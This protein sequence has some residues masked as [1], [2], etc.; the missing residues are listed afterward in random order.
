MISEIKIGDKVKCLNCGEEIELT[1]ETFYADADA[2]YIKCNYCGFIKDVQAYHMSH[3]FPW[4]LFPAESRVVVEA[5]MEF[6]KSCGIEVDYDYICTACGATM[7]DPDGYGHLW[8]EREF[9]N[10]DS[11]L[12]KIIDEFKKRI[13][14]FI[15]E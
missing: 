5:I 6:A 15:K 9:S 3:G 11:P 14:D 2:E 12:S 4:M 7:N 13:G 8:I 10:S 1:R